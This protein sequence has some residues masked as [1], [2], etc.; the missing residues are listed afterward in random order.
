MEVKRGPGRPKQESAVKKGSSS[1]K[2]ASLNVFTEKDPA[3]RYR[4]MRNDPENLSKKDQ[5]GWQIVSGVQSSQTKHEEPNRIEQG[6]PLTSV[7]EGRDWILGRIPE[8]VAQERDAFF[9]A[10]SARRVSGLTAHIK[11][12]LTKE[13]AGSHGEITISSR[14]G[15]QTI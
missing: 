14:Q 13:G 8:D 5:E 10:E 2:P 11:K 9:N 7:T 1:W 12:E 6:K 4:M 15:T 3:F